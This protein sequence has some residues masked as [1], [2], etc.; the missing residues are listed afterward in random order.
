[1]LWDG[2]YC[3]SSLSEKTRKS[4]HL[5]ILLPRQ[6][7]L[8]SY[9]KTL[10]VGPAGVWTRS[11]WGNQAAVILHHYS[12]SCIH[13]LPIQWLL[14]N[15]I[16]IIPWWRLH[17]SPVQYSCYKMHR[18]AE[19]TE[20]VKNWG[21][22]LIIPCA[23]QIKQTLKNNNNKNC[24]WPERHERNNSADRFFLRALPCYASHSCW[25]LL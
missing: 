25:L 19:K 14:L 3:F 16:K 4:N 24:E 10:S 12:W 9:F 11:L 5:Q 7:F 17:Q 1:M 2:T 23:R 22:D 15:D 6:H 13:S 18:N 21:P 8:L 20:I